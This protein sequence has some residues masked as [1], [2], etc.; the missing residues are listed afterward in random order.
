MNFSFNVNLS[1]DDYLKFNY[2]MATESDIGK[3]QVLK[4]RILLIVIWLI[5]ALV[6][7]LRANF[8]RHV[9]PFLPFYLVVYLIIRLTYIPCLKWHIKRQIKSMK[10]NGTMLYSPHTTLE[11]YD[12]FLVET[13][14]DSRSEQKY[15]SIKSVSIVTGKAIYFHIN[16]AM[17]V[18][19]PMSCFGPNAQ[20]GDFVEFV[21]KKFN[22]VKVY[23]KG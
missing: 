19:L 16:Y 8:S 20:Y 23:D 13:T 2:F 18:I 14:P 1:D 3:K 15:A 17:A 4:Y 9:L 5:G 22:N 21:Q 6:I 7:L 10:K 11:F 12:D